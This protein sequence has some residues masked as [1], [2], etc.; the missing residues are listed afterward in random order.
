M[1]TAA[2]TGTAG[3][4]EAGDTRPAVPKIARVASEFE[5]LLL[6]QMLKSVE[7]SG[8]GDWS[9]DSE[10]QTGTSLA[11]MA[12]EQFAQALAKSGGLG[13]AKMVTAQLA[14]RAESGA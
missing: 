10:D 8:S 3:A 12:Q 9:G 11:E 13:V 7:E 5:A 14:S 1:N 4:Y 6:A 2:L